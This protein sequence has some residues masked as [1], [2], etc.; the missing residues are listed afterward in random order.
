MFMVLYLFSL[1]A[2]YYLNGEALLGTLSLLIA[3]I[4]GIG[5]GTNAAAT[6]AYLSSFEENRIKYIGFYQICCGVGT[7]TGPLIGAAFYNVGGYVAPFF[8]TG[9]IYVVM[10]IVF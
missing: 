7:L 4:G 8:G 5:N 9:A 3:V 2:I 1:G 10:I 6:L